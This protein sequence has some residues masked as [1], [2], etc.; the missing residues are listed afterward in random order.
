MC[1]HLLI[2]MTVAAEVLGC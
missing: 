1:V 2:G